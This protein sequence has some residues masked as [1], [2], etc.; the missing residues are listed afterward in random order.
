MTRWLCALLLCAACANPGITPRDDLAARFDSRIEGTLLHEPRVRSGRMLLHVRDGDNTYRVECD[1]PESKTSIA[2]LAAD[3]WAE[4]P[5]KRFVF[6]GEAIPGQPWREYYSGVDFVFVAVGWDDRYTGSF[7]VIN[8]MHG[9]AW[10]DGLSAG[11][12]I[13]AAAEKAVGAGID[14]LDPR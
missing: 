10:Y 2:L 1:N 14:V 9:D 13:K 5:T 6:Y 8:A 11:E 12:I 3:M 7:V 4:G